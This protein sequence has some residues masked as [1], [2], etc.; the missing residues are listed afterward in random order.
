M[1]TRTIHYGVPRALKRQCISVGYI[2]IARACTCV[3][4]GVTFTRNQTLVS[5]L[6]NSLIL[7]NINAAKRFTNVMHAD[8]AYHKISIDAEAST[9]SREKNYVILLSI[10]IT[11]IN[12]SSTHRLSNFPLKHRFLRIVNYSLRVII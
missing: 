3:L 11:I 12:I 9:S 7:I 1:W 4:G 8:D 2:A 6:I 5:V 10:P